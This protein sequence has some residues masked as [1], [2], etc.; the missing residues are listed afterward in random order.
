MGRYL[1][2]VGAVSADAF[3]SALTWVGQVSPIALGLTVCSSGIGVLMAANKIAN[4]I[5]APEDSTA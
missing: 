4:A 1:L 5:F 2:T 3:V